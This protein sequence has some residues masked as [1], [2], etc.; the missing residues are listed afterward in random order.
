VTAAQCR[1]KIGPR[2]WGHRSASLLPTARRSRFANLRSRSTCPGRRFAGR[3]LASWVFGRCRQTC[4]RRT[5]GKSL[6][7]RWVARPAAVEAAS[8][9]RPHPPELT[10][11]FPIYNY[12][13]RRSPEVA[14]PARPPPPTAT[15][16]RVSYYGL[17]YYCPATGRWLSRD[18][19]KELGGVNLYG[20][21]GNDPVNQWDFLGLGLPGDPM[22]P[23]T[24]LAEVGLA[25]APG[26]VAT[27]TTGIS[28]TDV[29][30]TLIGNGLIGGAIVHEI[31]TQSPSCPSCSND[32]SPAQPKQPI[33]TPAPTPSPQPTPAQQK[34]LEHQAYKRRCTEQPPSGLDRCALWK[35]KLQRNHDCKRLREEFGK[36]WYNDNE[37]GHVQAIHELEVSIRTLE[38][39]IKRYCQ[40][41]PAPD[42]PPNSP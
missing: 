9:V 5:P 24:A 42:Q 14:A 26:V 18:P 37:P 6:N 12:D 33:I 38:E 39:N 16:V 21:V 28:G 34:S 36:K 22:D 2:F 10:L 17:R 20:M 25:E 40:P 27:G 11:R 35:W 1:R 15:T 29:A 31:T 8:S 32:P 41:C 30:V 7:S 19:I 23:A 13:F 3:K 4:V